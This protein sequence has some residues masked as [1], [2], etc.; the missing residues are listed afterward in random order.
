MRVAWSAS[1][2][3]IA[4]GESLKSPLA[5][6]PPGESG[7]ATEMLMLSGRQ[8]MV[9][10]EVWRFDHAMLAVIETPPDA[11]VAGE[12]VSHPQTLF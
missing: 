6:L 3:F 5:E 4:H 2:R 9:R 11:V 7:T 10:V 12:N 8:E 1:P